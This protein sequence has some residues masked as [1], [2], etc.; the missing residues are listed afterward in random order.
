M[1]PIPPPDNTPYDSLQSILE[2]SRVRLNDAIASIGGEV[3]TNTAVFSQRTCNNAWRRLQDMLCALGMARF[4][5]MGIIY[6]LP[7]VSQLPPA[8]SPDPGAQVWMNWNQY[9]DGFNFF[10]NPTLP[11]DFI[12][13]L[14]V[15]ERVTSLA[16]APT[17]FL[18]MDRLLNGIPATPKQYR[19]WTWDWHDDALYLAGATSLIDLQIWYESYLPDFIDIGG[20]PWYNSKV[21]IPRCLDPLAN[22]ICAEMAGARGDLDAGSFI[23]AATDGVMRLMDREILQPH[24]LVKASELGKMP[25]Q[26]TPSGAPSPAAKTV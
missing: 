24:S 22:L 2:A 4:K 8:T 16:N 17:N 25:D 9:F 14:W 5:K 26:Y 15:R 21:A 18:K 20:T 6:A 23:A 1:P 19:N 10:P 13:P 11:A 3:L 7:V 12:S